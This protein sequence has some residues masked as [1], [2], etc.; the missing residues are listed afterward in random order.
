MR[1]ARQIAGW[2]AL[3]ACIGCGPSS[4]SDDPDSGGGSDAAAADAT[5]SPDATRSD[6]ATICNGDPAVPAPASCAALGVVI[7]P[8]Y[9][10]RYSCFDLG[11]V[12][13]VPPQK[14]GGL[15]LLP[16][17]CQSTLVIGGEA[18]DAAG[19]LYAVQ[20]ARNAGGH[21]SGFMGSATV[22]ADGAFNDGGV[23]FGPG[24]VMFLARYPNNEL[25]ELLPGATTPDRIIDLNLLGVADSPGG[26]TF[27]PAGFGGAGAFKI[28]SWPGGE[29]Y[30][31]PLTRAANGSYDVGTPVAGPTL[32]GGPE[33]FTYVKAGS[34]NFAVDSMLVSEW[35]AN[36]IATYELDAQGDP[37]VSTRKSFLTG[38]TGAEGAYRDPDTGDFFFSTWSSG[39]DRVIVVRGFLPIIR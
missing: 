30:T 22:R 11:P 5:T 9:A 38:L 19:K 33:G 13:G 36:S 34:P 16:G 7:D 31:L 14:Y 8:V 27:V 29:W 28:V 2:L 24:G 35:S 6:A 25:G 23:V 1:G 18:N 10:A 15:T 26:M 39:A 37:V 12:P 4:H 21:I 20:V 32:T 17:T 3:A